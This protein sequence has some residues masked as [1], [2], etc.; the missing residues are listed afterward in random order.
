MARRNT[1]EALNRHQ[2]RC[3]NLKYCILDEVSDHLSALSI[4]G[5]SDLQKIQRSG[6]LVAVR[7]STVADTASIEYILGLQGVKPVQSSQKS[8]S[9]EHHPA[10]EAYRENH[11]DFHLYP[12]QV[13]GQ[14]TCFSLVSGPN[15][16]TDKNIHL[17]DMPILYFINIFRIWSR[18]ILMA[19]ENFILNQVCSSV[20]LAA[21]HTEFFY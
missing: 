15:L 1:A 4:W 12:M 16:G 17:Y 14:R 18:F 8:V 20:L 6:F 13:S 3:D 10:T 11:R 21:F 9:K 5:P 2:D 7:H 19:H